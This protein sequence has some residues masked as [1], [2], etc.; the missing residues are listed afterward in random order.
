MVRDWKRFQ[1]SL[2]LLRWWRKKLGSMPPSIRFQLN[3]E[4]DYDFEGVEYSY[5]TNEM[6]DFFLEFLGSAQYLDVGPFL[7]LVLEHRKESIGGSPKLCPN[8]HTLAACPEPNVFKKPEPGPMSSAELVQILPLHIP[9]IR[10]LVIQSTKLLGVFRSS[11]T[12]W[13][14]LTHLSMHDIKVSPPIWHAL[15]RGTTNLR[16]GFFDLGPVEQWEESNF[17]VVPRSA[18]TLLYLSTLSFATHASRNPEGL[19]FPLNNLLENVHLPELREFSIFTDVDRDYAPGTI[20]TINMLLK[21][22]PN[23]QKLTLGLHFTSLDRG[24]GLNWHTIEPL[25]TRVP[26]LTHLQLHMNFVYDAWYNDPA[27]SLMRWR[28]ILTPGHWINLKSATN[29]I[30]KITAFVAD[31]RLDGPS[32]LKE[33][34]DALELEPGKHAENLGDDVILE[35]ASEDEEEFLENAVKWTTWS[36]R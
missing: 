21:S 31:I 34:R 11:F 4:S 28:E 24:G 23:V 29:T 19:T 1:S 6:L 3:Q 17:V 5:L 15:I 8:L 25:S 30:R 12:E 18:A 16:W 20:D 13:S 22:A 33:L 27:E 10:R 35:V 14:G 9:P 32:V 2:E 7:L 36:V 26:S